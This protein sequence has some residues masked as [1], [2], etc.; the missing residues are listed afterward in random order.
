MPPISDPFFWTLPSTLESE[1]NSFYSS[2][3]CQP[4]PYSG[5]PLG[6]LRP[7]GTQPKLP[8]G[9]WMKHSS[10]TSVSRKGGIT[11]KPKA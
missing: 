8:T 3:N 2:T 10:P 5:G 7:D 6:T 9:F 1:Y 11:V 4:L